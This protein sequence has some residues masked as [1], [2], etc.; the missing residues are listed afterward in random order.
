[1]LKK[2]TM[3]IKYVTTMFLITSLAAFSM[4]RNDAVSDEFE[5]QFKKVIKAGDLNNLKNL[6]VIADKEKLDRALPHLYEFSN[7]IQKQ[8]SDILNQ[9]RYCAPGFKGVDA[10]LTLGIT[11]G[12]I[13]A[14]TGFFTQNIT[15]MCGGLATAMI[16]TECA[17]FRIVDS[18]FCRCPGTAYKKHKEQKTIKAYLKEIAN[19]KKNELGIINS[20]FS[21]QASSSDE[22]EILFQEEE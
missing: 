20:D 18:S 4:E 10:V 16:A 1:M 17:C 13:S 15:M 6:V 3:N 19:N 2:D 22:Y 9:A 14:T 12:L 11:G 21:S 5:N 8:A 7:K